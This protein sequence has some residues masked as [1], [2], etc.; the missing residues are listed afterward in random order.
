LNQREILILGAGIGGLAVATELAGQLGK[1]H[2][3]TVIDRKSRFYECVY[4]LGIMSGE[5]RDPS[6][7][8]GSLTVLAESGIEFIQA[9][10]I[11]IDLRERAV[12][13]SRG[14]FRS[15]FLV[16]AM[17]A[18]MSPGIVPGLEQSGFNIYERDGAV[19]LN[20][21][22]EK[23]HSGRVAILISRTPFKCPA[24]PYESAFLIDWRLRQMGIRDRCDIDVYTPEWQPMLSAGDSVGNAIVALMEER[25]IGY[26]TEHMI[27]KVDHVQRSML[28][29]IDDAQYD[30]LGYVP[31]HVAPA[32]V[33]KSGL[34]DSTGWIPVKPD[35]METRFAGVY[36][37]GDIVSIRLHN[38]VFLPMAGI[39]AMQEGVT[40]ASNI[41]AKL[42]YGKETSFTGEGYCFIETGEGKAAMGSGN[43]Y[44]RPSPSITFSQPSEEN[45]KTK[46]ELS[47]AILESLRTGKQESM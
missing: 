34:T 14:Q 13:T 40:V 35:S 36:A 46:D 25:N 42:G 11:E 20:Q 9:E 29:E 43:F 2:A 45:K 6:V 41:A 30:L 4:N 12:T 7:G 10:V 32:A 33:R 3:V 23:L 31:P 27:L 24:A 18:E 47:R 8:E 37:I 44:A 26:H 39:F 19:G 22:L 21:A 1:G 5:I 28:F 17:G 15:D 38:G 16:I